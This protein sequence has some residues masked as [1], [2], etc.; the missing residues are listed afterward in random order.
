MNREKEGSALECR[1]QDL[2]NKEV[3][4]ARDGSRLGFVCDTIVDTCTAR[5]TCLVVYGRPKCFGLL[6][7]EEDIVIKWCEIQVI[8]EDT[9]LVCCP[10]RPCKKR[11]NLLALLFGD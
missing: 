9:V 4:N 7:R 11:K 5:L 3:I 6:G 1:F 2:R 10:P 8:G